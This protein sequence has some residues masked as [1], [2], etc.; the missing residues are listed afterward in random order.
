MKKIV[1]CVLVSVLTIM[2]LC[3]VVNAQSYALFEDSFEDSATNTKPLKA[4]VIGIGSVVLAKEYGQ[5]NKILSVKNRYEETTV[6]FDTTMVDD[7]VFVAEVKV[8]VNDKNSQKTLLMISDDSQRIALASLDTNGKLLDCKGSNTGKVFE[9]GRYYTVS[10]AVDTVNR[11]C[12][13]YV[14]GTAVSS[15]KIFSDKFASLTKVGFVSA[16]NTSAE[17]ELCCDY[18]RL[19]GGALLK[20]DSEFAK[21]EYNSI[22]KQNYKSQVTEPTEKPVSLYYMDFDNYQKNDTID[23]IDKTAYPEKQV[24]VTDTAFGNHY[25]NVSDGTQTN[26]LMWYNGKE[27]YPDTVIQGDFRIPDGNSGKTELMLRDVYDTGSKYVPV[28]I[29]KNGYFM[30]EKKIF[31]SYYS[32]QRISNISCKNNWVNMAI[33]LHYPTKTLDVYINGE[34][35]VGDIPFRYTDMSFDMYHIRYVTESNTAMDIDNICVYKAKKY[36]PFSSIEGVGGELLADEGEWQYPIDT[37]AIEPNMASFEKIAETRAT[38]SNS[39]LTD[40]SEAKA[41]YEDAVCFV[42]NTSNLWIKDGKYKAEHKT[43]R[44]GDSLMASASVLGSVYGR[45][46]VFSNNGNTVTIGN[47][48]ASAGDSHMIVDGETLSLECEIISED[49]VLYLPVKEFAVYVMKKWY[50][51]SGFGFGVIANEKRDVHYKQNTGRPYLNTVSNTTHMMAYLLLDLPDASTLRGIIESGRVFKAPYVTYSSEELNNLKNLVV[52]NDGA[53][54]YSQL[55]VS[56]ANKILKT[57]YTVTDVAGAEA[58][59]IFSEIEPWTLYWAY[60]VTGNEVYVQ[61]AEEMALMMANL[62]HWCSDFNFL[63]TSRAIISSSGFYDL[64]NNEFSAETKDT[65]ARAILYKGLMPTLEYYNGSTVGVHN[66]WPT[67]CTNWNVIPNSGAVIGAITLLARGYDDTLCLEILEKA[68]ISLGYFMNYY[69]PDGGGGEGV[70]YSAFILGHLCPAID[71]L[72]RVFGTDFG[73]CDYPGFM[74]AGRFS[75]QAMSYRYIYTLNDE[76]S[77]SFVNQTLDLWFARK[78]KDTALAKFVYRCLENDIVQ[79]QAYSPTVLK[80]YVPVAENDESEL[81]LD[82][83][84]NQADV[85][86]S[87][88][89]RGNSGVFLGV[90]SG[91]NNIGHGRY[92]YGTFEFDAFGIR[93]AN[94]P[95]GLSYEPSGFGSFVTNSVYYPIRPEGHNVYVVNPDTEPGQ[96][97]YTD[98]RL[99]MKDTAKGGVIYTL[100]MRPAYS[101]YV[102][103][104]KRG[105]MLTNDRKVFV[106]Q[107]EIVPFENNCDDFYWFWHTYADI[108]IDNISKTA[109]LTRENKKVKLYFDCTEDIYLSYDYAKPLASSPSPD[110]QD[111]VNDF[112]GLKKIT[113]MFFG[114]GEPVT[115]RVIAVPEGQYYEKGQLVSIDEWK[116]TDMSYDE[117]DI[118]KVS[119]LLVN[120][121]KVEDFSPERYEYTVYYSSE[122]S[123]P[124]VSAYSDNGRVT[125]EQATENGGVAIVKAT[126]TDFPELCREYK[127]TFVGNEP[128]YNQLNKYVDYGFED[129]TSLSYGASKEKF[130]V[131]HNGGGTPVVQNDTLR[132]SKVVNWKIASSDSSGR[133]YDAGACVH[134]DHNGTIGPDFSQD[135]GLVYEFSFMADNYGRTSIS[136]FGIP[137]LEIGRDGYLYSFNRTQ[138]IRLC[139]YTTGEWH[140]VKMIY[141][142]SDLY[143]GYCPKMYVYLDD[144]EYVTSANSEEWGCTGINYKSPMAA[145][146]RFTVYANKSDVHSISFDDVLLYSTKNSPHGKLDLLTDFEGTLLEVSDYK[147]GVNSLTG[148][149]EIYVPK[150]D[151][152][153]DAVF[154]ITSD[155]H[156]SLKYYKNGEAVELIR[157][158]DTLAHGSTIYVPGK[159]KRIIVPYDIVELPAVSWKLLCGEDG[160]SITALCEAKAHE[161]LHIGAV[162]EDINS[163]ADKAIV[164]FALYDNTGLVKAVTDSFEISENNNFFV[165]EDGFML[166]EAGDGAYVKAFVLFDCGSLKPVGKAFECN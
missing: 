92:D 62:S 153:Y 12:T 87:R 75:A 22:V 65:I 165:S 61:K 67:R 54:Q 45:D 36:Y 19:Y 7:T 147:T 84:F 148:R 81:P 146:A 8:C 139:Q 131:Y 133:G 20:A 24:I 111:T 105:Y 83:V 31:A 149:H 154:K 76:K 18:I 38:D 163:V 11:T 56:E 4:H 82:E 66:D 32:G 100:D 106:L 128:G 44:K 162:A 25:L 15:G 96:N 14:D 164:V 135:G 141:D 144:T 29:D 58:S 95:G 30:Y 143:D 74:N 127:V 115:L 121:R 37:S 72:N 159:T 79:K 34:L 160:R 49:G 116:V 35:A 93:F 46:A 156:G 28:Y 2:V 77:E 118:P 98:G 60:Q 53:K 27:F 134:M 90:H 113:A 33:A 6:Y 43:L 17:S 140:N 129:I 89:S 42:H 119:N 1:I 26:I 136:A 97:R 151:T 145:E 47:M 91:H 108:E 142:R 64:F 51:F 99:E 124:V 101:G 39:R 48:T 59:P 94:E 132:G 109:T 120:G 69:A 166:S 50:G 55:V 85:A 40:Y 23:G 158:E 57:Q 117:D 130:F 137:F 104:A 88:D 123:V 52:T 3:G 13:L 107:D 71:A 16:K 80:N 138:K 21:S 68:F 150:G 152:L 112:P 78:N 86:F 5:N 41:A 155:Y 114:D 73:L 125:V 103:D 122:S 9:T 102:K 157:Y 63:L 10:A 70:G 110:G 126:S 161:M